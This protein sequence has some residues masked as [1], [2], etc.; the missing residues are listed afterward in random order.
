MTLTAPIPFREAVAELAKR[1]LMPTALGTQE[2]RKL[3]ADL[4]RQAFFS[5]RNQHEEMLDKAKEL[6]ESIVNPRQ[7]K[8]AD[9]I[10]PENPEGWV[11]E[12]FNPAT[13][14]NE[15]RR[16]ADALGL[17]TEPGLP[18]AIT[19]LASDARLDLIIK[20]N[21]DLARGYGFKRA[22]NTRGA[23]DVF[24]AWELY[25]LEDRERPRDWEQRF[26]IAGLNTG[27]PE[28]EGGWIVEGGRMIAIK[29]HPIWA[30]LGDSTLFD[31]ALDVSYPPFA[32]GSGM[33]CEDVDRD[34][35]EG[36]G[37]LLPDAEVEPDTE[38]FHVMEGEA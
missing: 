15:L 17:P 11:T 26:R 12:G 22:G 25:R 35:A 7:V 9:R 32:F 18:G 28:G 34:E 4:R 5:A 19:D 3:D 38:G 36:L 21:T 10:T 24:P 37:I 14:R 20:T 33:W 16:V 27:T 31:D 1:K 2:L 8:R 29:N 23:L 13:A 30:K 6:V